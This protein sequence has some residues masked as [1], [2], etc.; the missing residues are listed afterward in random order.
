MN[1]HE[2]W[3]IMAYIEKGDAV[4]HISTQ[5]SILAKNKI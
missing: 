2:P 1:T 4:E 3:K 5:D